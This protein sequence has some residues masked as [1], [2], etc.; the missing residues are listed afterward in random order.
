MSILYTKK[1]TRTATAIHCNSSR[2]SRII[3]LHIFHFSL[4]PSNFEKPTT[5]LP[6]IYAWSYYRF[7]FALKTNRC[8]QQSFDTEEEGQR[9]QS[10]G[11]NSCPIIREISAA[12]FSISCYPHPPDD[13]LSR[14]WII[15]VLTEAANQN[16][17]LQTDLTIECSFDQDKRKE[18]CTS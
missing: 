8:L 1:Q 4:N 7:I 6:L 17:Q 10:S 3:S 18:P 16:H 2:N 9:H 11:T 12:V 15:R 5:P 13:C 14:H